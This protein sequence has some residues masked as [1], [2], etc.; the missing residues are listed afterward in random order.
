[1]NIVLEPSVLIIANDSTLSK[2]SE[3]IN[4]IVKLYLEDFCFGSSYSN[5]GIISFFAQYRYPKFYVGAYYEVPKKTPYF[6]KTPIVEFTLGLNIQ[7]DK[8]RLS[9]HSH[10]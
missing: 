8:S 4:P 3:Y 9:N 5:K 10:W 2:I 7:T 1:M 6:K